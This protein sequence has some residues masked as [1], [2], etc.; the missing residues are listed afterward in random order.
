VRS[1]AKAPSAGSTEGNGNS[2]GLFG[3]VFV[4]RGAFRD[5]KGS[6][7]RS[8]GLFGL[9]VLVVGLFT[10][11]LGASAAVA[12]PKATPSYTWSNAFFGAG[13]G[14]AQGVATQPGTGNIATAN[15][16]TGV[17]QLY[18]PDGTELTSIAT[19]GEPNGIAFDPDSGDLYVSDAAGN[20]IKRYVSDGAPNP[21][22][23]IDPTFASPAQ[24]AG[25]GEVG[26]FA[27][28]I[29]VDPSNG[30]VL[31]ADTATL[32]VSRYS[33]TGSFLGSFDGSDTA[34]GP[35]TALDDIGVG[36]GGATYVIDGDVGAFTTR[37]EKFD[38]AGASQG[39]LPLAGS[40]V[41]I[42]VDPADGE[43]HVASR[44]GSVQ[45]ENFDAAGAATS[46][47]IGLSTYQPIDPG[48]APIA[49]TVNA[50]TKGLYV[51]IFGGG[52]T[53]LLN[54]IPAIEPPVVSQ[55]TA[56]SAHLSA[57]YDF[58]LGST[59]TSVHFEYCLGDFVYC[60]TQPSTVWV[61]TPNLHP[62]A[63]PAETDVSGLD[64]NAEYQVRGVVVNSAQSTTSFLT[65]FQTPVG[66]P[67]AIT[68]AATDVD[69]DSAVIY[70]RVNPF[71]QQTTYH[72][73]YGTTTAYGT[74]IPA[75]SDAAAGSGRKLL[76]FSRTLAG[77][78]PGTTYHYRLIAQSPQ[79]TTEGEDA[80]FT[81]DPATGAS[82]RGFEQ[83]T[84]VN[85]EGGSPEAAFGASSSADGSALAYSTISPF[86]NPPGAAVNSQYAGFRSA[87]N[88]SAPAALDPP[89][90]IY[91]SISWTT[92]VGISDDTEHSFV[93]SNRKLATGAIEGDTNLYIHDARTDTYAFVAGTSAPGSLI[94]FIGQYKGF[95]KFDSGAPD[96][97][98]VYFYSQTPLLEGVTGTAMYR[99]SETDGL[100]LASVMPDGSPPSVNIYLR[101]AQQPGFQEV[102]DDGTTAYFAVE[103]SGVYVRNNADQEQS[104]IVGGECT[105]PTKAC[106]TPV[107]VSEVPGDPSTPRPG[108]IFGVSHDGRYVVFADQSGTSLTPDHIAPTVKP[109]GDL[110]RYDNASGD[111]EYLGGSLFLATPGDIQNSSGNVSFVS[112]T[113]DTVI[114]FS[115]A[116]F[117]P[118]FPGSAGGYIWHDGT[119]HLAARGA[120]VGRYGSPNGRY[121][122]FDL[123]A[124]DGTAQIYLYDTTNESRTCVSCPPDGVAAQSAALPRY[125]PAFVGRLP[126]AVTDDGKVFFTTTT[127][128]VAA[129][130]NG[131]KDVYEYDNGRRAL[132][133]PGNAPFD[134]QLIEVS[135][136]GNDV[137]FTTAQQ[138]VGQDVFHDLDI[139][140]AR[141][142]G[143]LASQNPPLPQE[144]IRD[145]CKATP[146]SGPELPFGGSEAISGPGNVKAPA[147]KRCGKGTHARKVKGKSRCVKTQKKQKKANSNRR[148]AR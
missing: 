119:I 92:T 10:V 137:F 1:H 94:N 147:R 39:A 85:K 57:E 64:A 117:D 112:D 65:A 56:N 126:R 135:E 81:T 86:G 66:P 13:G 32:R 79:G 111:L 29:A 2:R 53:Y 101:G 18:T 124:I 11:A 139:Y 31:I 128:V 37:V 51:Q 134:A 7:A 98:W 50:A 89:L 87:D 62:S 96:F 5:S 123:P 22:F 78:A 140:D 75:G 145:D 28:R 15:A 122:L 25:T 41:S 103:G 127:R 3:R 36:P 136:S 48:N 55:I 17:V 91:P 131:T 33:D 43:V 70:G 24:G 74:R 99:W 80:I 115:S 105:E 148:Q 107:S 20:T 100:T 118:E 84:P 142:G 73:E 71:G 113:A 8:L 109:Y 61:P 116:S 34:G 9:A 97:S 63:S 146:G 141:V 133:S 130:T 143:G 54:Y 47:P 12:A 68:G 23:T 77:L 93:A 72:F 14:G 132:V 42:A 40:P 49:L 121:Y 21:T 129:D 44:G 95:N 30:D 108:F 90:N 76:T 106:T 45:I 120:G 144:C 69:T 16:G 67:S 58:G 26:S 102:S 104:Q 114:F 60:L 35:F 27:S 4:A 52:L 125:D 88:W 59:G 83:V 110:Y 6:G 82:T 138:L 46:S 19:G 38:S